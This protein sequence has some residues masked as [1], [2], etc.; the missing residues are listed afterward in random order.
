MVNW[1]VAVL[2]IMGVVIYHVVILL[3]DT[4]VATQ[5]EVVMYYCGIVGIVR[6]AVL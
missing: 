2:A 4:L 3:H 6:Q 1:H 5:E